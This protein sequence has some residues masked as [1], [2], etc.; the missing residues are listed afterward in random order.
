MRQEPMNEQHTHHSRNKNEPALKEMK[1]TFRILRSPEVSDHACPDN[2]ERVA[3]N[4][5]GHHQDDQG[6]SCPKALLDK[7]TKG[8][9]QRDQRHQ[10]TDA[11]ACFHDL[12]GVVWQHENV[13]FSQDRNSK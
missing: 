11:T 13:S 12:K 9:S 5:D 2:A 6:D 8:D 10:R 3:R 1:K 7:V 4:S